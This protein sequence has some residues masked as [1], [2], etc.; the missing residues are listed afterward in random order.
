MTVRS[1]QSLSG[2]RCIFVFEPRT[3]TWRSDSIV[4]LI[5]REPVF[6]DV[7]HRCDRITRQSL[8]WSLLEEITWPFEASRSHIT[9]ERFGPMTLAIAMAQFD[10]WQARGLKP[11]AVLGLSSGEI[12]AAYA[13]GAL[14]LEE[15]FQVMCPFSRL[16]QEKRIPE[17]GMAAVNL[18]FEDTERLCRELFVDV[19]PTVEMAPK[20]TVFAGRREDVEML[21]AHL[22][23]SDI[24]YGRL[25]LNHPLHTPLLASARESYIQSLKDLRPRRPAK[26]FYSSMM[27]G[28]ATDASLDAEFWWRQASRA[29]F[30]VRALSAALEHGYERFLTIGMGFET[31]LPIAEVARNLERNVQIASSLDELVANRPPFES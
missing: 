8:G 30:F 1:F 18:S 29:A 31:M 11:D 10:L 12:S 13:S 5:D 27:G 15:A 16:L 9:E 26:P 24:A 21:L 4:A 22:D 23:A 7:M 25:P 6:A 2:Q 19:F 20:R 3:F 14:N 28:L 17:G